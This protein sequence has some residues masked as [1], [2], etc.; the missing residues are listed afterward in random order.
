MTSV[1]KDGQTLKNMIDAEMF[2]SPFLLDE[3][4]AEKTV[5]L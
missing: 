3:S 1:R 2:S 4:N 5:M